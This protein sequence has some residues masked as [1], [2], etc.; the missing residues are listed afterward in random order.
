VFTAQLYQEKL[1]ELRG[2]VKEVIDEISQ[3][4]ITSRITIRHVAGW[5]KKLDFA[6]EKSRVEKQGGE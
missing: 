5:L 6:Y 1:D 4:E 3:H 2:G